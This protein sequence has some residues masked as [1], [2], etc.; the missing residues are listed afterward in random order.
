MRRQIHHPRRFLRLPT[1][2]SS[3]VQLACAGLLGLA[4]CL[5]ALRA[6]R[7]RPAT[8][9]LALTPQMTIARPLALVWGVHPVPFEE[10]HDLA[11]MVEH[12][13]SAALAENFGQA[14]DVVVVIAG[15]PFGRSGSTNLL[16]VA[17]IPG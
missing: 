1:A 15:L 3:L 7:E 13:A 4:A 10:V 6:S 16:H 8:P 5:P 17:R 2:G 12:A 9:I 11:G 14:G